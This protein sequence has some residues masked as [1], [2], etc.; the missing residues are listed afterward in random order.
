V[1]LISLPPTPLVTMVDFLVMMVVASTVVNKGTFIH[2]GTLTQCTDVSSHIKNECPE[3]KKA[4]EN[5]GLCYNC[6]ESG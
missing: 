3:P 2:M 4:V 1:P 5:S 6:G